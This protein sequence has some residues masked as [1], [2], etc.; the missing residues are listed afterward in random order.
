MRRAQRDS[1]LFFD[2]RFVLAALTENRQDIAVMKIVSHIAAS[3]A[4]RTLA[5]L[6]AHEKKPQVL[7]HK[8]LAF[9]LFSRHPCTYHSDLL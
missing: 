7:K 2:V 1:V 3:T 4:N 5:T 9:H 8:S 6:I